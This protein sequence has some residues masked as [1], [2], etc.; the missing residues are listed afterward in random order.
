MF[1]RHAFAVS[2]VALLLAASDGFAAERI[3]LGFKGG[4]NG[5]SLRGDQVAQFISGEYGQL[6]GAID[7]SKRGY[8]LG[9]FIR[10][11]MKNNFHL[12]LEALWI[13]KGGQ[14]GAHGVIDVNQAN[15]P[16]RQGEFNGEVT[17]NLEYIEFPLLAVFEFE[18][19]D[20]T[21]MNIQAG[22]VAAFNT[23][24]EL[25]LDGTAEV[26]LVD[27]SKR[28]QNVDQTQDISQT[29]NSSD[30]LIALGLGLEVGFKSYDLIFD[31][32]YEFGLTTIDRTDN[33]KS[34]VYNDTFML[35]MG[36]LF[37]K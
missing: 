8:Q 25:G 30:F 12:Q 6:A 37:G 23:K 15:S 7:D 3:R 13:Q 10:R 32:R 14:G 31:A 1:K 33:P 16:A 19:D 24:A 36:F 20:R 5:S 17:V 11:H 27:L 28:V 9:V 29:V 34:N 35:S 22:I 4:I 18:S 2:L 26:E 21:K